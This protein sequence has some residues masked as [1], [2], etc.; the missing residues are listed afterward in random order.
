M[1][2]SMTGAAALSG[3]VVPAGGAAAAHAAWDL[4]AVN[5]RGLDLRLRLPEGLDGLE[6][7][8]RARLQ[9]VARRGSVNLTLKLSRPEEAPALRLDPVALAAALQAVAQVQTAAEEAGVALRPPTAAEVL[10]QRGVLVAESE[11]G[12]TAPLVA[13]LLEQAEGLI[14]RFDAARAAEGAALAAV[15]CA[16]VD[17]IAALVTEARATLPDRAT[18]Q[19]QTLQAGVDRLL[20]TSA[21]ADPARLAQELA[22][23]AVRSDVAE[24]LDRLCAHVQAARRLLAQSEPAG[25]QLDFL[26]QELNREANTLSSK[27]QHAGLSR[28]GLDL[29][30]VIDQMRE[31]VQN[32]E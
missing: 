17:R 22:L 19:A 27:A 7:G 12:P 21:P 15:L 8:L 3:P 18:D 10:G 30:T 5:G 23:L 32:L 6:A 28:I 29:K 16:Q 1:V 14:A 26:T 9:A 4:R 11:P 20:A 2:K 13:A 25:R 24:E 31:Q